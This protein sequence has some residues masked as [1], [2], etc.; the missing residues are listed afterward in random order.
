MFKFNATDGSGAKIFDRGQIIFFG[1]RVGLGWVSQLLG[2][3]WVWKI[4][5]K[6]PNFSLFY[7]LVK[8]NLIG[9][10]QKIARSASLLLRVRSMLRSGQSILNTEV[11]TGNFLY[12]VAQLWFWLI[13]FFLVSSKVNHFWHLSSGWKYFFIFL[14]ILWQPCVKGC[15]RCQSSALSGL[16]P[17][18][19][20]P[21]WDSNQWPSDLQSDAMTIRP[22]WPLSNSEN[23]I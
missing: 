9:S 1:A 15:Q 17:L 18:G 12:R 10:G 23:Y 16:D 2:L 19:S 14:C 8:K 3:D 21:L 4:S 5:P 13:I 22:R 11:Y 7:L 6:I 20:Y